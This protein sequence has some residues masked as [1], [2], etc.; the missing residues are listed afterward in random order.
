MDSL[1]CLA[2]TLHR[3]KDFGGARSFYEKALEIQKELVGERHPAFAL[4][5]NALGRVIQDQG[6]L[7]AAETHYR[8]ALAVFR[9]KAAGMLPDWAIER[10]PE[11]VYMTKDFQSYSDRPIRENLE[12]LTEARRS[13]GRAECGRLAKQGE[14]LER[15]R[16][17]SPKR[18][19]PSNPR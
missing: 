17:S 10:S 13:A 11:G 14:E 18:F 4:T 2:Q 16:V 3:K 12:S 5:R 8:Q 1:W 6:D 9:P 19:K 15:A 7:A